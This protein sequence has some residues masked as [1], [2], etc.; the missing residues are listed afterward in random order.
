VLQSLRA[1]ARVERFS[2]VIGVDEPGVVRGLVDR[3]VGLADGLLVLDGAE[4]DL[5]EPLLAHRL[6][7]V[8]P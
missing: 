3:V 4:S 8:R 6:R 1:L 2:V 5:D 7:M